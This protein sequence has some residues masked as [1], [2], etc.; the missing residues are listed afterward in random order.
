MQ[1]YFKGI[2]L[3]FLCVFL[4]ACSNPN[5]PK[6]VAKSFWDG[7]VA[8]DQAT[9]QQYATVE[10]QSAI[11]F[12][13]NVVDWKLMTV[14]LGATEMT[15]DHASVVTEITD[16]AKEHQYTFNTYLVKENG[17][18]RVDYIRTRHASMTSEVFAN[19][20]ESLQKLNDSLVT[21]YDDTV[22]G[23]EQASPAIRAQLEALSTNLAH[24]GHA[25]TH[26][27][28]HPTMHQRVEALKKALASMFNY[29][30]KTESAPAPAPAAAPASAPTQG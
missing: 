4:A 27:T 16:K 18:W 13:K 25:Q 29:H 9:A 20:V 23:F 28:T 26:A 5:S 11:D 30:H 3:A 6:G 19:L 15:G 22:A 2:L 1:Q 21:H 7:V 24:Q 10:T 12:S 17:A 14:K 8:Q